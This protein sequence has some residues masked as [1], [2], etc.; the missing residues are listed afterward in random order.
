[1]YAIA[2]DFLADVHR[3]LAAVNK[4]LIQE[5]EQEE[6]NHCYSAYGKKY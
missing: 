5:R 1:M 2:Q 4:E 3:D 6:S